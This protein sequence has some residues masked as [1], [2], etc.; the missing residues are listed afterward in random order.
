[1][2]KV[3]MAK[4]LPL[5]LNIS[6]KLSIYYNINKVDM[7]KVLPLRLKKVSAKSSIVII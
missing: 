2:N 1:M 7:A 6:A 4:V 5:R 3:D